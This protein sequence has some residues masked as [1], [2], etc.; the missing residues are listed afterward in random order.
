M[1]PGVR[2]P[3]KWSS[4]AHNPQRQ[5]THH[6]T[7]DQVYEFERL[8]GCSGKAAPRSGCKGGSVDPVNTFAKF[9]DADEQ[10][11]CDPPHL[12]YV[13][14]SVVYEITIRTS[15]GLAFHPALPFVRH[16][17]LPQQTAPGAEEVL[18][19]NF[20]SWVSQISRE[21]VKN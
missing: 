4:Q 19:R 14:L 1:G 21:P 3:P 7:W 13:F 18:T 10:Y 16:P 5:S 11:S 20:L 12:C 15:N 6:G 2:F 9:Y 17:R 8:Y